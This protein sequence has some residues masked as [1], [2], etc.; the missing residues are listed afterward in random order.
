MSKSNPKI[1]W[2]FFRN[3]TKSKSQPG[4]IQNDSAGS[5]DPQ[6]KA[7]LFNDYFKSV[8]KQVDEREQDQLPD[9][10]IICEDHLSSM[11]FN[12]FDVF[13]IL[14]KLDVNKSC[15]PDNV[16]PYVLKMCAQQITPSLTIFFNLSMRL[17]QVPNMWKCAYVSPIHKKGDRD[18][19][20][21]YRPVSLL[22][23]VSKIIERCIYNH[24]YSFFSK[25]ISEKQHGFFLG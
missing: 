14:S 11:C 1:F 20:N 5:T 22:S 7:C 9:I 17:S 13:K 6:G 18:K 25:D 19:V 12:D 15:G 24:I 4:K 8:F 2:S 10:P 21:N 3:K 16:S 23:I